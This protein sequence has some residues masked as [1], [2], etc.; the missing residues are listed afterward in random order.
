M[1]MTKKTN[2]IAFRLGYNL[3]WFYKK[4]NFFFFLKFRKIIKFCKRSLNQNY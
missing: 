1:G 2:A 3:F 4:L